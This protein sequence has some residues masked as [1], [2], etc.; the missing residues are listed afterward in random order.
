ML[1]PHGTLDVGSQPPMP[2]TTPIS[3][4]LPDKMVAISDH[5]VVRVVFTV[6]VLAGAVTAS[7]KLDLLGLVR[8]ESVDEATVA[9]TGEDPPASPTLNPSNQSSVLSR[10]KRIVPIS[11]QPPAPE[12]GQLLTAPTSVADKDSST[13]STT[14]DAPT[15][16]STA[17]TDRTEQSTSSS[18]GQTATTSESTTSRPTTPTTRPRPTTTTTTTTT[19]K[20]VTTTSTQPTSS[21]SQAPSTTETTQNTTSTESSVVSLPSTATSLTPAS[22]TSSSIQTPSPGVIQ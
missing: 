8:S 2:A 19:A 9:S 21:S 10:M 4:S 18:T 1:P 7:A 6:V 22:T 15:T 20:P 3:L 12:D 5:R 14:D 16:D 17:T 11:N 13:T